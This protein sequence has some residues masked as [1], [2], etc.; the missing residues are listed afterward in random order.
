M[1]RLHL[2]LAV[3][4]HLLV[5]EV[6]DQTIN[7]N[8]LPAQLTLVLDQS[9]TVKVL[10]VK[11][12]LADL[13]EH[14]PMDKQTLIVE[15]L[16]PEVARIVTSVL[17]TYV[18]LNGMVKLVTKMQTVIPKQLVNHV[19]STTVTQPTVMITVYVLMILATLL[20]D[21]FTPTKLFQVT[22]AITMLVIHKQET[23]SL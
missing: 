15:K 20:L 13:W 7:V 3:V 11:I 8:L 23:I 4:M 10:H 21:V 12:L 16:F 6:K 19:V 14:G 17:M 5:M 18:T 2:H 22:L 9:K 1:E